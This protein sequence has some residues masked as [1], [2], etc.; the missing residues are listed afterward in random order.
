MPEGRWAGFGPANSFADGVHLGPRGGGAY[1][2]GRSGK[3][4]A[5]FG[6]MIWGPR[7]PLFG[8]CPSFGPSFHRLWP[9]LQPHAEKPCVAQHPSFLLGVRKSQ[10]GEKD[11]LSYSEGIIPNDLSLSRETG[12]KKMGRY[13]AEPGPESRASPHGQWDSPSHGERE[14]PFTSS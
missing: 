11:P 6:I 13:G 5:I 10:K 2:P 14:K 4:P 1:S 12:E 9:S 3:E 8:K 7:E